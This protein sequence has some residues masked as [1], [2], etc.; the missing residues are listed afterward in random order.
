MLKAIF[1]PLIGLLH[2]LFR[3]P[4]VFIETHQF[5]RMLKNV[6]EC[7]KVFSRFPRKS[8][9]PF[10]P[11]KFFPV[12]PAKVFLVKVFSRFSRKS[13]PVFPANV[14]CRFSCESFM[15]FFLPAKV[16]FLRKCY[17]VFLV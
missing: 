12:F 2:L 5:L 16:V 17:A 13:F 7:Q 14:L 11:E 10:F 6:F 1:S 3:N 4:P 9:L 15:P 8:V